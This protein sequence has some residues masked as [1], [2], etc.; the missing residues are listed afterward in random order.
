MAGFAQRDAVRAERA[1]REQHRRLRTSRPHN[2]GV[3]TVSFHLGGVLTTDSHFGRY[4]FALDPLA[5]G[6]VPEHKVIIGFDGEGDLGG[7]TIN[8]FHSA[9]GVIPWQVMGA[10]VD[11]HVVTAGGVAVG[12]RVWLDDPVEL[13]DGEWLRPELALDPD[14][15]EEWTMFALFERTSI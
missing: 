5:E 1:R 11:E 12:N 8:W 3:P 4:L 15:A 9:I 10:T 2:G 13:N 6:Y 7:L 14:G